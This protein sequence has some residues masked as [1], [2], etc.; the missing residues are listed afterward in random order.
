MFSSQQQ[1]SRQRAMIMTSRFDKTANRVV[2]KAACATL[3]MLLA[4]AA[5]GQAPTVGVFKADRGF[6]P[7]GAY[8]VSATETV[9]EASGGLVFKVPLASLPPARAGF[10]AGVSLVY[11]S[12]LF[13]IRTR[14]VDVNTIE[15]IQECS[16]GSAN[17]GNCPGQINLLAP[18]AMGG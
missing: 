6:L 1:T 10:Q 16:G 15:L 5:F 8:N 4:K 18:A 2:G 3:A 12:Q 13:D 7:Y 14:P 9:N 17:E 11:N